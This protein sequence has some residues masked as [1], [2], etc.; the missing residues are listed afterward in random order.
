MSSAYLLLIFILVIIFTTEIP[1][2]IL[3]HRYD[4]TWLFGIFGY[5][6]EIADPNGAFCVYNLSKWTGIKIWKDISKE[7]YAQGFAPT[8]LYKICYSEV[9]LR[10]MHHVK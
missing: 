8:L 5:V 3:F 1:M 4:D 10:D 6:I 7:E 2:N 9:S